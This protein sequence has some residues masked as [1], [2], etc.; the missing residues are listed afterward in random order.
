MAKYA[1]KQKQKVKCTP[2]LRT[3]RQKRCVEIGS[4]EL[5][6]AYA[7]IAR[8][9]T[10]VLNDRQYDTEAS[11]PVFKTYQTKRTRVQARQ[12]GMTNFQLLS[13]LSKAAAYMHCSV[14]EPKDKKRTR[15]SK[16]RAKIVYLR[17]TVRYR[18]K[19]EAEPVP[20]AEEEKKV[21]TD[22]DMHG[23]ELSKEILI[24]AYTIQPIPRKNINTNVQS[25]NYQIALV[26][27]KNTYFELF[28]VSIS[29]H[30][31]KGERP[32]SQV[33]MTARP[34]EHK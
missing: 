8:N 16:A 7:D 3:V 10:T 27:T 33:R 23:G 14:G 29:K 6:R 11:Q 28:G 15:S 13:S 20:Q 26:S 5:S 19:T 25:K 2:I 32:T 22:I 1:N 9:I 30:E 31:R 34:H 12:A 21:L 24:L 4:A 17:T 18:R